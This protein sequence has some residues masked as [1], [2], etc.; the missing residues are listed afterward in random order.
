MNDRIEHDGPTL[1]SIAIRAARRT[2]IA[3]AIVVLSWAAFAYL[4]GG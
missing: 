1:A 3:I 4:V 2:F